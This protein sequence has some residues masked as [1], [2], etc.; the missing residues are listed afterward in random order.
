VG[1]V[2]GARRGIV[3]E[4]RS[5]CSRPIK[6]AILE[7]MPMELSAAKVRTSEMEIQG[8]RTIDFLSMARA[9]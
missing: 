6:N 4:G 1:V 5:E 7:G 8:E 3:G 9:Y 2:Q